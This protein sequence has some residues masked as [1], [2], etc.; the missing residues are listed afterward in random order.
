[1][2]TIPYVP[3]YLRATPPTIWPVTSPLDFGAIGNGSADD[4]P[5]I[6]A[7]LQALAAKG[8]GTLVFPND[9]D[10]RIA[11][12]GV[13][14]IHLERP[15]QHH[16][17][18]GRAQPADHGQHGRRAGGVARHLRRGAVREHL[19][20]R[21][22]RDV[23]HAVGVAPDLGADLLPR[24]QRRHR[25]CEPA[26]ARLVSRQPRRHRGRGRRS[27]R[28]RSRNVH[29]ENVTSENSP[30]VGIGI[31]GVDGIAASNIT[32]AATPGRTASITSTS[33]TRG[34]TAIT[35][36]T[37][38]TTR[39]SIGELRERPRARRHRAAVPWRG[40]GVHQHRARGPRP[41][42]SPAGSIVPLGVRDVDRRRASSSSIASAASSSSPARS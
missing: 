12:P 26:P 22:A 19:A 29:L 2:G 15:E 23:R 42:A 30:S 34:S 24:R 6:T 7:A 32:R 10:F 36:S 40:L 1:M 38:A 9:R 41:A 5:A 21:R 20:D 25:R 3:T 33:A 13:H 28:A 8:G 4:Y 35:A 18:D 17:H 39:I 27:R 11:T 31:V 14:G 16:D 37:S